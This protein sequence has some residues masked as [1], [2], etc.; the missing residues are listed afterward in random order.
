MKSLDSV[1]LMGGGASASAVASIGS[2]PPHWSQLAPVAVAEAM[3]P[4]WTSL[5]ER[6]SD[7]PDGDRPRCGVT[8]RGARLLIPWASVD[9]EINREQRLGAS[10]IRPLD[11]L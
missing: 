6:L 1:I 11:G 10:T 9:C 3:P 4:C 5:W 7:P 2:S 8:C